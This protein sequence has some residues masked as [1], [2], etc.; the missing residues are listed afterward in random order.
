MS[1]PDKGVVDAVN[2]GLRS[3]KG[4][5]L[6]IQSSDDL[7][8]NDA[9]GAAVEALSHD[10]A[11]G[12]VYGDVE[13]IDENSRVTGADIQGPFDLAMYFGRFMYVPQPGTFFTRA[14][15][16]AVDGWRAE[17]SYAADADFWLRI[18]LR[19]PVLQIELSYGAL[20]LS[21]ASARSTTRLYMLET[22]REWFVISLP[23]S[24][25]TTERV[26]M[27]APGSF[28]RAIGMPTLQQWWV[29][30]KAL[31]GAI[32]ANP[33][34]V[35]HPGFPRRELFPGREPIWKQLSRAK[36]ALGLKPRGT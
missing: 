36:R 27:P 19:F 6:T 4:E 28:W 14:A 11:I 10:E 8:V 18:A 20:S 30:T 33:A 29:R 34:V 24:S 25:S 15:M 7:F 32:L 31:Y 1:E 22:G 17:V 13:L 9:I 21:P 26:D 16:E 5:I 2:K 35:S 3:A 12:L 23:T